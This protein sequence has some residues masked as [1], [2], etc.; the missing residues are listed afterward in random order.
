MSWTGDD[1]N[2]QSECGNSF[3]ITQAIAAALREELGGSASM[4]KMAARL[5]NSNERAVRNWLEG[6]NGPSG[7]NL[8]RLMHHSDLVLKA[9]LNLANRQDLAFAVS[10]GDVR[11]E[12]VNAITA[13]DRLQDKS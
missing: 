1:R 10:L 4:I 8:V 7:E 3:Q 9:V 12:L 2:F 5:T 11:R 6:K 13:I